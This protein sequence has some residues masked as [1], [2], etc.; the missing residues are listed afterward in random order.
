MTEKLKYRDSLFLKPNPMRQTKLVL[1]VQG[2]DPSGVEV[3]ANTIEIG[4]TGNAAL[5]NSATTYLPLLSA[6]KMALHNAIHAAHP[7]TAAIKDAQNYVVK[8]LIAIKSA[9]ELECNNNDMV[10]ASSG[11]SLKQATA[12]TPKTFNA[13]QGLLSGT[14]DLVSPY[15][16]SHAAYVWEMVADPINQNTWTQL[17]VTNN[18]SYLVTGLTAGNK[19]WFRVKAIVHDDEQPY[20]DP[21]LVH[22]V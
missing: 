16:G 9:V 22:V 19:Y 10:A 13:T 8:V 1:G 5:S 15:A 17:K 12:I 14:V 20:T 2:L 18:T 6:G 3:L 11:F 4:L 21:H 7:D